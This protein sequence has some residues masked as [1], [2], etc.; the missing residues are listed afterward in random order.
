MSERGSHISPR[1][2]VLGGGPAGLSAAWYLKQ[3]GYDRVTVLEKD[4]R[5]GGKCH[6]FTHQG[7]AIELGA[8]TATLAYGEVLK[9]AKAVGA[10][11]TSQPPRRAVEWNQKPPQIQGLLASAL[12]G[13][14]IGALLLA[15]ARYMGAL[16][17][18]RSVLRRPG[19][20]GVAKAFP[21]LA[22]P[23]QKFAQERGFGQL[24]DLFR[25]AVNDMGYGDLGEI[26]AVYVLR[27]LS[28]LNVLNLGLYAIGLG[29]G[30][31]KRFVQGYGRLWE[32]VGWRSDL[33]LGCEV[34]GVERSER[35]V[36][37]SWS[38][39]TS[40]DAGKPLR[41]ECQETFAALIVSCQPQL[42]RGLWPWS[43][44]ERELFE[45]I[46][47][48][49]YWVTACEVSGMPE[50]TLDA[51]HGL[52]QGH[53]WEIMRPWAAADLG[54]FYSFGGHWNDPGIAPAQILAAIHEDM[55]RLYPAARVGPVVQ[56]VCWEYFAHVHE[57][58]VRDGFYDQLESLQGDNSTFYTGGTLAFETVVNVVEYSKALVERF[59]P[60]IHT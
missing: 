54:V 48:N 59:F 44:T 45:Q 28:F 46:R 56:Q 5:A 29:F 24:T 6:S 8:F 49:R 12:I 39:S 43:S 15:G 41:R 23:Y 21:E 2:C 27:Y 26:S 18:Y 16:W 20:A 32:R 30:W 38:E 3:R 9:I 35:G 34:H 17:H 25:L 1:I 58:A 60:P 22:V 57:A 47:L 10:Q 14:S 42:T 4:D 40:D 13:T 7:Q 53:A 51:I 52:E 50:I 19:F 31:P 37:V 55:A 36:T 33:R 11:T